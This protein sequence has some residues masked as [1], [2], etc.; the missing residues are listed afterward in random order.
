MSNL[1]H[2]TGNLFENEK[3][4][5]GEPVQQLGDRVFLLCGFARESAARLVAAV[6]E[7][8][9]ASPF[10]FMAVRGGHKMSVAMTNCGQLGWVSDE[11]GYRYD[12][13]DPVSG[14]PW[15][16]MPPVMYDLAVTAAARA[17]FGAF[18]PDACLINRYEPGARMGLHQD[19]NEQDYGAPIVSVSL[20]LPATFLF[21]GMRRADRPQRMHLESGDVVVWGGPARLAYHG[22]APLPDG[23]DALTG[24]S[25]INLTFRKAS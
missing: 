4:A 10:R 20:G 13:L 24:R 6:D 3:A 23:E 19:K 25:R 9:A 21:G 16:D 8:A 7:V 12:S 18:E 14:N 15:P 11:S 17:G 2:S 22:V 1:F 5:G